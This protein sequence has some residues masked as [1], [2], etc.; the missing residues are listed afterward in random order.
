MKNLKPFLPIAALLIVFV[1]MQSFFVVNQYEN[2]VVLEF[3]QAKRVET[4]AGLKFK[5]PW[6][7]I[8]RLDNR[9]LDL[10]ANPKEVRSADKK[11]IIVDAF[12]KY[13][14]TDPIKYLERVKTET[15]LRAQF[16]NVVEDAILQVL[17]KVELDTMLTPE[18]ANVMQ[19][20]TDIVRRQ[21][22]GLGIE[23]V[24]VR[25]MRTDFPPANSQKIYDRMKAE[26]E[27]EAKEFRAEGAEISK[28]ITSAADREVSIILAD[29]KKQAEITRG[30]GDQKANNIFAKSYG[31]DAEFAAFYRSMQAYKKALDKNDTTIV[32]NPD[33]KFLKHFNGK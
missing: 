3:G 33:G 15:G 26:R 31:R 10:N 16:S 28:Q 25:I 19:N 32:V 2:V 20:I 9:V 27:R 22:S 17:G 18:R 30:E 23:V 7:D 13:K 29:A 1:A 14:I 11:Q 4:E 6:Q 24:D 21:S 12:A 5:L 8:K